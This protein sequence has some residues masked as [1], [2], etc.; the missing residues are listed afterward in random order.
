MNIIGPTLKWTLK[1]KGRG[2]DR[3]LRACDGKAS[4]SVGVDS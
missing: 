2:C 4:S 1:R 3:E